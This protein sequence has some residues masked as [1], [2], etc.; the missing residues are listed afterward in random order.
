MRGAGAVGERVF[1][2]GRRGAWRRAVTRRLLAA[3]LAAGAVLG[4][5]AVARA[6]EGGPRV[7]VVVAARGLPAGHEVS[8]GDLA[9]S[10]RPA[11][12]APSG[13]PS[14]T[15]ALV[16][17]RLAGPVTAGEVMSERRVVGA[18][19]LAGRP[20]DEVAAHVSV[21]DPGALAMVRPGDSVD[22]VTGTGATVAHSATVLAVGPESGQEAAGLG[23]TADVAGPGLVLAVTPEVAA[24]LASAPPHE[25]GGS[26]LTVV[27]RRH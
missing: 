4:G 26:G 16:G 10:S 2:R 15:A 19:L 9:V 17:R 12:Y 14:S 3:G 23:F 20:A 6:P 21:A 25:T 18:G 24:G 13:A 27:L 11:D 7:H 8:A 5:L 22:V 1:G